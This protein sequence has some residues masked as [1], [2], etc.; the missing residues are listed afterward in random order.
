MHKSH[1]SRAL[2]NS[3][4]RRRNRRHT[5]PLRH[6]TAA[7]HLPKP[8][9][10]LLQ[11][12]RTAS[13]R[14]AS[15]AAPAVPGGGRGAAPRVPAAAPAHTRAAA[16]LSPHTALT[17]TDAPHRPQSRLSSHEPHPGASWFPDHALQLLSPPPLPSSQ[18]CFTYLAENNRSQG[19]LL[20]HLDS[21]SFISHKC[22]C[23]F[24]CCFIC[25]LRLQ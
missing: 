8:R 10:S 1:R 22:I 23:R 9:G 13:G 24:L 18:F 12:R 3:E 2:G 6:R 16:V 20:L 19:F 4:G 14:G 17:P 15:A 21:V 11:D 7:E 25:S 5:V